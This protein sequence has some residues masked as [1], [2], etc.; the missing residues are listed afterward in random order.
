MYLNKVQIIGNITKDIELKALP[1]GQ[2]VT[3]F[4]VATK[5][6]W[7]DNQGVK[8][9]SV[10]YHNVVVFGKQAEI[11]KQYCGKGDQIFIEGRLQTRS[12]ETDNG[13][14]YATEIVLE[15]F[16]FGKKSEKK[17][18]VEAQVDKALEAEYKEAM[19]LDDIKSNEELKEDIDLSSIPF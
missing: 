8:Q 5:R 1:S 7:K 18:A 14:R 4:S 2:S 6:T 15:N 11:I 19:S 17:I 3:S 9:E 16:Q 12:W 10:D 13:K